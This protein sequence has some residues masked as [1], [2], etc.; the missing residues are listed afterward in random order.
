M[1]CRLPLWCSHLVAVGWGG[2]ENT[3]STMLLSHRRCGRSHPP[4]SAF[5]NGLLLAKGFIE[6]IQSTFSPLAAMAPHT[7]SPAV[8]AATGAPFDTGTPPRS[9]P[10]IDAE[11]PL[12]AIT[13][14]HA[15]GLTETDRIRSPPFL[16]T[17]P[18]RNP[19]PKEILVI[20]LQ[21]TTAE[22]SFFKLDAVRFIDE[23]TAT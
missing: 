23:A 16:A 6:C 3:F 2:H 8:S 19:D 9:K 21:S 15:L 5:V 4:L 18:L 22:N 14:L 1:I 10:F 11:A 17:E 12:C 7:E 20:L 13:P